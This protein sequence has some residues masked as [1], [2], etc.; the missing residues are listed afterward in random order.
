MKNQ[1]VERSAKESKDEGG[2]AK[3]ILSTA[4]AVALLGGSLT[5]FFGGR[6]ASALAPTALHSTGENTDPSFCEGIDISGNGGPGRANIYLDP[7]IAGG[8]YAATAV[9]GKVMAG[10][11]KGLTIRESKIQGIGEVSMSYDVNSTQD[12]TSELVVNVL[13][14]NQVEACPAVDVTVYDPQPQ[15]GK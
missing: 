8:S 1:F 3:I 5:L 2:T 11:D 14:G 15:G 9:F 7:V 4:A 6:D 13:V 10:Y 12:L